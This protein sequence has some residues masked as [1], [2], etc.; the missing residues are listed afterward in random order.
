M[1]ISAVSGGGGYV[2]RSLT[3]SNL[4]LISTNGL[5][6]VPYVDSF[7]ITNAATLFVETNGFP[8]GTAIRGR[9]DRPFNTITAAVSQAQSG[10]VIALGAGTH[11]VLNTRV[12][13]PD[14]VSLTGKGMN[15]SVIA[16]NARAQQSGEGI[17]VNPGDNSFIGNLTIWNTNLTQFGAALGVYHEIN[18]QTFTNVLV[19]SARLVGTTD[20]LYL[21]SSNLTSIRLVGC[22]I[23]SQWDSVY[24]YGHSNSLVQL[25]GCVITATNMGAPAASTTT[26]SVT[27]ATFRAE[28]DNCRLEAYGGSSYAANLRTGS[29][30]TRVQIRNCS[31]NGGLAGA[32][33]SITN[34]A[35][36]IWTDGVGLVATEFG[37]AG[38]T[39]L[40]DAMFRRL[41]NTSLFG[42]NTNEGSLYLPDL[43]PSRLLIVN[44]SG[45]MDSSTYLHL[46]DSQGFTNIETFVNLGSVQMPS[47]TPGKLLYLE[48]VSN[49]VVASDV[50]Y[51]NVALDSQMRGYPYLVSG[52]IIHPVNGP[53][54]YVHLTTNRV[55]SF[56]PS[57]N[58]IGRMTLLVT[59]DG[60]GPYNITFPAANK[61]PGGNIMTNV[62][63]PAIFW[64]GWNTNLLSGEREVWAESSGAID[65]DGTATTATDG[66]ML[67]AHDGYWI[68]TNAPAGGGGAGIAT[69]NGQGTNT[70]LRP[71][72][73]GTNN[74]LN[75]FSNAGALGGYFD[76]NAVLNAGSIIG[77]SELHAAT[78]L[79]IYSGPATT[80]QLLSLATAPIRAGVNILPQATLH[81][82]QSSGSYPGAHIA[83]RAG[84]ISNI[85]T[86]NGTNNAPLVTLSS[87]GTLFTVAVGA[88]FPNLSPGFTGLDAN[89]DLTNGSA[90]SWTDEIY[91]PASYMISNATLGAT[92]SV[93]ERFSPTNAMEDVYLFDDSTTNWVQF[94]HAFPENWDLGAL[95]AK[96]VW[97]TTN[98]AASQTN[99]WSIDAVAMSHDDP[100]GAGWGTAQTVASAVSAANDLLVSAATAALTVGGSPASGDLVRFRVRRLGGSADDAMSN[101]QARLKGIKIQFGRAGIGETAW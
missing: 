77:L 83:G 93:E 27:V 3:L 49:S 19:N 39:I 45:I 98:G 96:F 69:L 14:N 79:A 10:D 5:A 33:F 23:E 97:S 91:I 15:V 52:D 81:V 41:S 59:T 56:G 54:Q 16:G 74:A 100:L 64:F 57:T 78:D 80:T 71:T 6:S 60:G 53:Y 9:P 22:R 85:V 73:S 82:V 37:G 63:G 43:T 66:F 31:F 61:M 13:L 70:T 87:N 50:Q 48:A 99:V 62:D 11:Y 55:F 4:Y 84:S 89:K 76:S 44:S 47:V 26:H 58:T 72:P 18:A 86:L 24:A 34:T 75:L 90:I 46:S 92:F 8:L 20:A 65:L 38:N 51:D 25:S 36:T 1:A 21:Y 68:A 67:V 7:H 35:G 30:D 28:L 95:K 12:T 40:G 29:A 17:L 42:A 2:S 88:R 94:E 101:A 32:Y